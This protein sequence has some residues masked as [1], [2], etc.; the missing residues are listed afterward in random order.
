M[1]FLVDKKGVIYE[2]DLGPETVTT[3]SAITSFNADS[4]WRKVGADAEDEAEGTGSD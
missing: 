1:T 4:T 3:A 2:K